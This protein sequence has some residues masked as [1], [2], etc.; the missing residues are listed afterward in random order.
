M[1]LDL[2]CN[3]YYSPALVRMKRTPRN[4]DGVF[5]PIRT[6]KDLLPEVLGE[7]QKSA[8]EPGRD[9]LGFWPE[10]IGQNLAKK[11]EAV[12]FVNGILTVIVKSSTLYS[13]L[14]VHEKPR[15]LLKLREAFPKTHVQNI[16]F[17]LG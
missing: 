16:F 17:R 12:S 14:S 10:I 15:L 11:T 13:L 3:L 8:G 9:I 2:L 5:T 1:A 6:I 4:Y 7:I